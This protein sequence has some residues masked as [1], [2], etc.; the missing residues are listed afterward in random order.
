M[1]EF[2]ILTEC[3]ID[4]L[5]IEVVSPP[6]KGYNHK[7][8]CTKVLETM[9]TKLQN[10]AALGVIDND[11]SVPKDFEDFSLLKKHNEQLSIYKHSNKP[12]YIIKITK[13]AEDFILKNAKKSNL[14]LAEYDL[15]SDLEGLKKITKHIN[16]LK[17]AEIR[18][19]RLFSALKQSKNTDFHKL[20]QGIEFFKTNPYNLNM[21]SL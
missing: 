1:N 12:H 16:S 19:K 2:H 20:T 10:N 18:V 15:P 9:K 11:K 8:N 21:E 6:Q 14:E 3:Y 17:E 13:A 4:T 5:L 7:H